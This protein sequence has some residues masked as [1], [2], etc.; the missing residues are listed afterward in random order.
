MSSYTTLQARFQKYVLT[1]E[2]DILPA[3]KDGPRLDATGRL[4]VYAIGYRLRM[5][6]ILDADY[7]ALHALAGD[8]LFDQLARAYIMAH[9]SVFPNARWVGR[10]LPNFLANDPAF[11]SQPVLAEMAAFEWAMSL[12]F[13]S[14][15]DSVLKLA[16]LASLPGQAWSTLGFSLQSSLQRVALSWNVPAFWLAVT[17]EENPPTPLQSAEMTPWIVWRR[18]LTTYFRSLETDE[19]AALLVVCTN[20]NFA[21]LCETLCDWHEPDDVPALAMTLLKRWIDE[22][23]VS[24]LRLPD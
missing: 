20:G 16:E 3:I 21:D 11:A 7:P 14:A 8:D 12:A 9:P 19:A 18:E 2:R 1:G 5:I 4:D 13:D 24:S 6:E 22:G 17:R 10:H 23:L 15:D